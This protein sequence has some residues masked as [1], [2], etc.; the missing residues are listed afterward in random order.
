MLSVKEEIKKYLWIIIASLLSA[1]AINMFLSPNRLLSGGTGGIAVLVNFL[2]GFNKG[3]I[4]L[5]I[6]IPLFVFSYFKLDK[7]FT[8]NSFITMILFSFILGITEDI[9]INFN[10]DIML[11][12]IFGGVLNGVGMGI[13]FKN[14]SSQGGMDIIATYLKRTK[15]IEIKDTLMFCNM[16]IVTLGAL[17][18][19]IDKGLYTIISLYISYEVLDRIKNIGNEKQS[20]LIISKENEEI[21]THL[22]NDMNLSITYLHAEGGYNED[23]KKVIY[24]VAQN[25][26]MKDI[27]SLVNKIDSNA[28]ISINQIYEAKGRGLKQSFV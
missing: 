8:I 17:K 16:I 6:N 7:K 14:R 11:S 21:G 3:I 27:K 10:N 1:I 28:V 24:L 20:M 9:S 12:C 2:T 22:M 5:V 4:V 18:F 25:N 23:S 19:G 26:K 13:N 15:D